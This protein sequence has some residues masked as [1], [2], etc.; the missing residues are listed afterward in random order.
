MVPRDTPKQNA[1]AKGPEAPNGA[2]EP[3]PG[4][5]ISEWFGYR[6]FPQVARAP[7]M[8]DVQRKRECPFL[9]ASTGERRECI[10]SETSKGVCTISSLSAGKRDDWLVC[11]Y[12]A[13]HTELLEAAA[14]QLFH[15]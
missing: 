2:E 15:L 6:T 9:S 3:I 5:Y 14:R 11:P 8:I 12:R 7:E 4:N 10:N 1:E 13:V